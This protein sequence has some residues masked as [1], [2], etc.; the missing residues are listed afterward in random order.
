MC[1]LQSNSVADEGFDKLRRIGE[2]NHERQL[3]RLAAE[4]NTHQANGLGLRL[5]VIKDW[6]GKPGLCDVKKRRCGSHRVYIVGRHTDC[7]YTVIYV[8]VNKRKEDD[9]PEDKQFQN[10]LLRALEN[11]GVRTIE[12][13]PTLEVEDED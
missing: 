8:M 4:D 10:K 5:P 9:T 6:Q 2:P 1:L 13:P 11:E 7:K 12:P 3:A